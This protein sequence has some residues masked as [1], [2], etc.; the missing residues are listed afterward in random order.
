LLPFPVVVDDLYVVEDIALIT[1]L[2]LLVA[3]APPD[4]NRL[5]YQQV[6]MFIPC[7]LI[8]IIEV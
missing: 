3:E 7:N 8:L 2:A 5:I 1:V 4:S 6:I